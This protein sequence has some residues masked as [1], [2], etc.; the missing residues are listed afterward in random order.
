MVPDQTGTVGTS[1]TR[2]LSLMFLVLK[3]RE[4]NNIFEHT[5]MLEGTGDAGVGGY[6][7]GWYVQTIGGETGGDAGVP[8]SRT[9]ISYIG[10]LICGG[11]SNEKILSLPRCINIGDCGPGE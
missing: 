5:N 3:Y 7:M 2:S 1:N 11:R 4:V 9:H 8:V 10:G 6:K